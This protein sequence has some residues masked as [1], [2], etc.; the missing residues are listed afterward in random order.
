MISTYRFLVAQSM[1][2]LFLCILLLSLINHIQLALHQKSQFALQPKQTLTLHFT[3]EEWAGIT[4]FH[5][6]E[7]RI[8]GRMFDITDQVND[9]HGIIIKG[10]F[11][12]KEDHLRNVGRA[13]QKGHESEK[14]VSSF[15]F[16]PAYFSDFPKVDFHYW[17]IPIQKSYGI[18]KMPK[19]FYH[20]GTDSPP[21]KDRA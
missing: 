12:T 21:P 15:S 19:A 10:H 3:H 7:I 17:I 5:A 11:D 14:S 1:L 4:K 2:G 8:Q 20:S 6:H 18:Y 16:V 13:L 9:Q